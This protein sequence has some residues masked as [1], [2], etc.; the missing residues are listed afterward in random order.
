MTAKDRAIQFAKTRGFDWAVFLE[1]SISDEFDGLTQEVYGDEN[2]SKKY[3]L[4]YF[5]KYAKEIELHLKRLH[6]YER[7]LRSIEDSAI[8]YILDY[9]LYLSNRTTLEQIEVNSINPGAPALRASGHTKASEKL[10]GETEALKAAYFHFSRGETDANL[11]LVEQLEQQK[12][13]VTTK[14][15]NS[16][17]YFASIL[18]RHQQ[19]DH[20]LNFAERHSQIKPI[21][22]AEYR[23]ALEKSVILGLAMDKF[24]LTGDALSSLPGE[25]LLHDNAVYSL[26]MWYQEVSRK[27][28]LADAKQSQFEMKFSVHR[29]GVDGRGEG[30]NPA[31]LRALIAAGNFGFGLGDWEMNVPIA[32]KKNL[33]VTGI[34][35]SVGFDGKY[36]DIEN[37]NTS[38]TLTP[39]EQ[40]VPTQVYD[41]AIRSFK[42]L[43]EAHIEKP[44]Y[45]EF[46]NVGSWR[47]RR[48]LRNGWFRNINPNGG[49]GVGFG[50]IR[51][52]KGL[53]I[54]EAKDIINDFEIVF[55]VLAVP[56]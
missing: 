37:M 21:L 23:N 1:S 47:N 16:D 52:S 26:T 8:R 39:P 4:R 33:R 11:E 19:P 54:G 15:S 5:E 50:P 17:Q 53:A 36:S 46:H 41:A 35:I 3:Q 48:M 42:T 27:F 12:R 30:N 6:R 29:N 7:Q 22:M 31:E 55:S 34:S 56:S 43:D 20:T 9:D 10:E 13:L 49:W 28:T 2:I 25:G 24:L 45:I 18:E 38:V 14:W 51:D 32:F 44:N 40:S